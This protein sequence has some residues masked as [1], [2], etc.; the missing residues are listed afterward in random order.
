MDENNEE[1]KVDLD[2]HTIEHIPW[3]TILESNRQ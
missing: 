2:A 1:H 3:I